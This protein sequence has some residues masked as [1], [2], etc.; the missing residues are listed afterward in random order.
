MSRSSLLS[1][2]IFF[3]II[4]LIGSGARAQTTGVFEIRFNDSGLTPQQ[5]TE[6]APSLAA[7]KSFWESTITGYQP[8]IN[9]D[10]VDITVEAINIDGPFGV[11]AQAG[12]GGFIV[13]QGGFTFLTDNQFNSSAGVVEIDTADFSSSLIVEV[14]KHEVAHVLGFGTLFDL[15]SLSPDPG[16]YIGSEGLSAYQAEYDSSAT[17]VPLQ[18]ETLPGGIML[19]NGHLDEDNPLV[20]DFGRAISDDLMTP[21]IANQTNAANPFKNF[22]SDTSLAIFRDLGYETI[23]TT[24][25]GPPPVLGDCNIDGVVTFLDIAPFI[26]FLSTGE[27]LFQA[28]CNQDGFISFLDIAPFIAIL[29]G[30]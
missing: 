15:N 1:S 2:V 26:G 9:L 20:D 29:S 5:R 19:A 23:S 7:T 18:N 13:T 16:E 6:L 25:I 10:G 11:L 14:L 22:L 17:F 28:D 30:T 24:F 3:S 27:F 4:L 21:I 8:G 12:P